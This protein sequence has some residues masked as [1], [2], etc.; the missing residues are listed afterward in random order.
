M[1]PSPPAEPVR[2]TGAELRRRPLP[3][4][5]SAADKYERGQVLVVGG[6]RETP[7]AVLLAGTAALRAGAGKLQMGTVTTAAP[8]LAVAVPEA[9]VMGLPETPGGDLSP[10]AADRLRER[11]ARADA[12]LVGPGALDAEAAG[13]LLRR[14][15]SDLGDAVL[16]VDAGALPVLN[17]EPGLLASLRGRAVVMPN[18]KE[19][20]ALI[21]VALDEVLGDPAGS[22]V[23]AIER[24]GA[25]VTLRGAETWTSA[26]GEPMFVDSAGVPGLAVSGSGDVLSG[27]IAGLAAR[28]ADPLTATLW[29]TRVHKLAGERCAD[30]QGRLGYLARD[31]LDPVPSVLDLLA[32]ALSAS[33]EGTS[34]S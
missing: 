13:A 18:P 1:R 33:A 17:D 29:A 31:L 14:L 20:A 5:G 16:V 23:R 12:V 24:L 21:G 11:V 32:E 2:V 25:T 22:V 3:E 10:D 15:V 19:M 7:G 26:P 28:G 8:A 27:L 30:E 34:A 9:G 4:H 6:S